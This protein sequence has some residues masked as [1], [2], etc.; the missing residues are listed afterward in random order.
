MTAHKFF[1]ST[2]IFLFYLLLS[3]FQALA[4]SLLQSIPIIPDKHIYL[5]NQ[6]YTIKEGDTLVDLAVTF[7]V[8]YQHLVLANPGVDPWLPK[9]NQTIII[10]YQVL[11]PQE[12]ILKSQ[13]PYILVNLPEMRLYFF[14]PP[15]MFIAPI[16]IGDEGKLPPLD[17]YFIKR[18]KEKPYWYPPPS[19]KAE[20]PDL[21]DVVPPGPENPM[22]EYA[23]YLSKGL[24]AIHGTNKIY[25][26]GRRST[27]GCIRM[28]PQHIKFLYETVPIGTKVF[29]VYEPYKIAVEKNKI[30]LQAFPDIENKI[31][32]PL[33]YIL[34][35]LDQ[36]LGEKD[37][38]IDLL[39][40]E[41]QF[42]NPDGLVHQ[43]GEVKI[44]K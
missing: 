6:T 19:I 23:L 33:V 16:G 41:K 17:I 37:Y 34:K 14:N 10:P 13:E 27:H 44:S 8:G 35:K 28:Y 3:S 43:I 40:L 38:K 21:P 9:T 36:L 31:K 32:N 39:K 22:G 30:Y 11:V 18:K 26:I 1:P 29:I 2:L 7:E 15:F 5:K 12:F 4:A 24:Y 20:D 25:S 42:E